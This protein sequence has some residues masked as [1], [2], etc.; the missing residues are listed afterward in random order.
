M[1]T[2]WARKI[3]I[4][5][6]ASAF[7]LSGD[8]FE[9]WL[10]VTGALGVPQSVAEE[11]SPGGENTQQSGDHLSLLRQEVQGHLKDYLPADVAEKVDVTT[12]ALEL[13][14]WRLKAKK[15]LTT[16]ELEEV[17]KEIRSFLEKLESLEGEEKVPIGQYT[18]A[19]IPEVIIEN[20]AAPEMPPDPSEPAISERSTGG[21][22]GN[23]SELFPGGRELGTPAS[24]Q[25]SGDTSTQAAQQGQGQAE[26]TQKSDVERAREEVEAKLGHLSEELRRKVGVRSETL[27]KKTWVLQATQH[28]SQKD[29]QATTEELKKFLNDNNINQLLGDVPEVIIENVPI[30]E[31]LEKCLGAHKTLRD[32]PLDWSS[33][34]LDEGKQELKIKA[35][36]FLL[37][38]EEKDL[39][40][41]IQDMLANCV[42]EPGFSAVIVNMPA[43]KNE[44]EPVLDQPREAEQKPISNGVPP[45]A[46]N[47][48]GGQPGMGQQYW[49]PFGLLTYSPAPANWCYEPRHRCFLR[50]LICS[51]ACGTSCSGFV[52]E[53]WPV[54]AIGWSLQS[55]PDG[56]SRVFDVQIFAQLK[57]EVEEAQ[58]LAASES[59]VKNSSVALHASYSASPTIPATQDL[60]A[61]RG[62]EAKMLASE[63]F[64]R[65]YHYFWQGEYKKAYDVVT[66]GINAN[67]SDPRLWYYKGF[68]EIALNQKEEA[69][70]S[71]ITA[72][73]LHEKSKNP[74]EVTSAIERVQG[75]YRAEL[76]SLKP[77]VR[78]LLNS[79][80]PKSVP[81]QPAP[82]R[83]QHMTPRVAANQ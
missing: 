70:I 40:R 65:G 77:Q 18:G 33:K 7:L 79:V 83:Q 30:A 80:S 76:E 78:V 3:R 1:A 75:R 41:Q 29:L 50:R 55:R 9:I 49:T 36:K 52:V 15:H 68:C 47:G 4:V 26:A 21:A 43:P 60:F 42:G 25:G 12:D 53:N 69:R 51:G 10:P 2:V 57:S 67:G 59:A 20:V 5:F 24:P 6:V 44:S 34:E 71:L 48:N 8:C 82:L 39:L 81:S 54:S 63:L 13:K 22:P 45:F 14:S 17:K 64:G 16:E 58:K 74:S 38:S 28:L 11:V 62:I 32:Q 61:P 66:Q 72:I 37:P 27:E 46:P 56:N 73:L 23:K 31:Q 19:G 35:T